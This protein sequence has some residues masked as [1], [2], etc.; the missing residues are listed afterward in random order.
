[1]FISSREWI[2]RAFGSDNTT[3]H[4]TFRTKRDQSES[5]QN[6]QNRPNNPNLDPISHART[7]AIS[8]TTTRCMHYEGDLSLAPDRGV[9]PSHNRFD[10][11]KRSFFVVF[12][13]FVVIAKKKKNHMHM[14]RCT[15]FFGYVVRSLG[16]G[17]ACMHVLI[18]AMMM[19]VAEEWVT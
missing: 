16:V 17:A 2:D 13:Q 10:H 14:H 8:A 7:T 11:N 15:N 1:M 9:D 6:T 3:A 12:D 4:I 19:C 18:V 5:P